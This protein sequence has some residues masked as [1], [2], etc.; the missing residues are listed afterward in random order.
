MSQSAGDAA[1]ERRLIEQSIAGDEQAFAMLIR[2]HQQ[3]IARRMMRFSRDRTAIEEMVHDVFV[4]AWFS[5]GRYRGQ[6]PWEHW[7]HRIAVRVGYR[8]WKRQRRERKRR[9]VPLENADAL[10]VD[11]VCDAELAEPVE[12]LLAGLPPR[13]RLVL[14]LLYVEGRSVEEAAELAGWSRTMIKVQAFRARAKLRRMVREQA[15]VTH[16]EQSHERVR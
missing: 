13:D 15:V 3:E 4:E 7:L 8:F 14:T 11:S 10:S 2:R 5:L 9:S 6:A 12:A 16:L 1:E